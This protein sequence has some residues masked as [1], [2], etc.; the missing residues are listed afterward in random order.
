M[1]IISQ[2]HHFMMMYQMNV[3]KI[4]CEVNSVKFSDK[5]LEVDFGVVS[6]KALEA[7][8][9]FLDSCKNTSVI[10][11]LSTFE[12]ELPIYQLMSASISLNCMKIAVFLIL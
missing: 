11:K 12:T 2:E 1:D 5:D 10:M 3:E 9:R 4:S 7:Y 8:N 6:K